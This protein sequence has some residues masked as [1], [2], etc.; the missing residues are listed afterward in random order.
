MVLSIM[1]GIGLAAGFAYAVNDATKDIPSFENIKTI[2]TGT[3]IRVFSVNG[4]LIHKKG[5]Q[6]GEWIEYKD[7]PVQM[8]KAIIAIE[9]RRFRSHQGVD[10][11]ALARA[12]K[13]AWDNRGTGRRKQGASTITQQIARTLFLSRDYNYKRKIDEMII[14]MAMEQKLSKEQILELYLNQVYFGGGAFG[15][16]AASRRFFNHP[17]TELTLSEAALLAGLVKAP[18]DYAPTVDAKAAIGRMNVVLSKMVEY[19]QIKKLPKK[20]KKPEIYQ[21]T[22]EQTTASRNFIDWVMK[23]IDSL[24]PNAEGNID[25]ITTLD[26]DKQEKA[27][28]SL[29]DNVPKGAQGALVSMEDDGAIRAMVGGLD[30]KESMYNRAVDA[31]RQPGSSFKP[32]VYMAALE[33]GYTPSSAVRDVPITIK[34]WSPRNSNGRYLGKI[35]LSKALAQSVNTV[36][37]SLGKTVGFDA[38]AEMANRLGVSTKLAINPSL[39]LGASEVRLIDM[40]RSYAVI[41]A[42]GK[43]VI[44]YGITKIRQNDKVI[45]KSDYSDRQRIISEKTASNM[46]SM[47]IDAINNGTGSAAAIGRIAAGKTG[48]TSSNKDGW[49]IGYSTGLVTGV[50]IGRDDAKPIPSLQGGRAPARIF[51]SYMKMALKDRP[52]QPLAKNIRDASDK[53]DDKALLESKIKAEKTQEPETSNNS[54]DNER[55]VIPEETP[56]EAPAQTPAAIEGKSRAI[57]PDQ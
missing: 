7:I 29:R 24:T 48:T 45:Y 23:Q 49:F 57:R 14:A 19:K 53:S 3:T 13:H 25:I 43:S 4:E 9:D 55:Q 56:K 51:S 2:P 20:S 34:G 36:A 52:L 1:G 22:K 18:S 6:Y 27:L 35:P 50:W 39:A 40:V 42:S 46:T 10:P 37:V 16:D 15:I 5:P 32:F 21:E 8:R 26:V 47:M 31:L 41:S 12:I 44:P 17:A 54:E 28:E 11:K 38:V 30:W 33:S